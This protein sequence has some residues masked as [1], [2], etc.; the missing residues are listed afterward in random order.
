VITK[1]EVLRM[2]IESG[3]ISKGHFVLS[4]GR[5]AETY[6][7][8]ARVLEDPNSAEILGKALAACVEEKVDRVIS[9]ILG[10]ILIG[11]EVARALD[12]PFIFP[13][14]GPD[15]KF[16][17]RRGF[18]LRP[19]E[20]VLIVE[21]VVT[22]G[23]TTEEVLALLADNEA[24]PVGLVAI[25][26]RSSSHMVEGIPIQALIQ[27]DF[28]DYRQEECPLCAEGIPTYRPGSRTK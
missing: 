20:R 7:Q 22:S 13:E 6:V 8:C 2:F 3:A 12:R 18:T 15:G 25:V 10:G 21:D 23:R 14:R 17:L 1:Q 5:H 19:Q 11:Y 4:S 28:P 9:P 27:L 24:Q 26:D 16:C